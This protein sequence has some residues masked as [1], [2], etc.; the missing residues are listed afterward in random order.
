MRIQ[1]PSRTPSTARGPSPSS[2][3]RRSRTSSWIAFV[4]REFRPVAMTKKSVYA[5]TGRRSRI[6]TS[7]ASF[8]WARTAMRRACSSE[9]RVGESP[10]R[11]ASEPLSLALSRGLQARPVQPAPLDLA[12][13]LLGNQAVD[14]PSRSEPGSDL[15][16]RDRTLVDLE[17]L[18]AAFGRRMP[19]PR[20]H[21]DARKPA[22]LVR[23]LPGLEGRPLVC[24]EDEDRVFEALVAEQV[25]RERMVVEADL[26]E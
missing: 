25:D 18:D 22:H 8:S 11:V 12:S 26:A 5:V 15:A 6:T 21:R 13:N 23:L 3:F 16:R 1:S 20:G 9:V 24:A 2:P 7:S 19:G 10:F 4:G 17:H 14:G